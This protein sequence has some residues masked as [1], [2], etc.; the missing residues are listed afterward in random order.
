[1]YSQSRT[2]QHLRLLRAGVGGDFYPLTLGDWTSAGT[3]G[4]GSGSDSQLN[5]TP[6]A[7]NL[8]TNADQGSLA[9]W[10]VDTNFQSSASTSS[11][12]AFYLATTS[13]SSVA[14]NVQMSVPNQAAPVKPVLQRAD[15]S[16]IGTVGIGPQ[17]G[18]VTQTNMIAFTSSGTTLWTQPYDTPQIATAGGGVIGAS[19]TTYD[20]N[21]N[22]NGQLANMPTQ[23]WTG[24]SYRLGSVNDVAFPA[25]ALA[26][27]FLIWPW[28]G[29]NTATQQQWYPPLASCPSSLGC[30]GGNVGYQ[31]AIYNALADLITRLRNPVTVGKDANG[32]PITLGDLAQSKVFNKLGSSRTTAGFLNYLTDETPQFNDALTSS[33]CEKSLVPDVGT[34]VKPNCWLL[35][36]PIGAQTVSEYFTNDPTGQQTD[37]RTDTPSDPL[38]T[39][40]RPQSIALRNSGWNSCNESVIVHEA[41]HGWTGIQDRQLESKFCSNSD[42][43]SD[44]ITDSVWDNVLQKS[45]GL[46]ATLAPNS[47]TPCP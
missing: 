30:N 42:L 40:F 3:G 6:S 19:G 14:S 23:S 10:E 43:P 26:N 8:I 4:N 17:P 15:G 5:V 25:T 31:Q 39:F 12:S 21:G 34:G 1:M 32:N 2:L 7:V 24:N 46:A 13:G 27:S 28:G 9:S 18:R 41:L 16:Y 45:P 37:A 11:S 20:Q 47:S 22:A 36:F 35:K 29:S 33:Y 44:C 38:R